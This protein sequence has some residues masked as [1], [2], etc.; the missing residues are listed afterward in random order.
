MARFFGKQRA[1]NKGTLRRWSCWACSLHWI[2]A[3]TIIIAICAVLSADLFNQRSTHDL[4]MAIHR[5]AGFCVLCLFLVRIAER[6]RSTP[7]E[8]A[9]NSWTDWTDW[10]A[11]GTHTVLYVLMFLIP[12][13]GWALTNARGQD[14]VVFGLKMP[15]IIQIYNAD[16][17]Y[18]LQ[19]FHGSTAWI[20]IALVGLHISAALWHHFVRRDTVLTDMIWCL[21]RNTD[22]QP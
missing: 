13:L 3:L 4:M 14:L 7:E 1:D 10:A 12:V 8:I 20:L 16:L 19:D 5:S 6:R 11:Q 15:R 9:S 2:T 18:T 22:D 17:S 21:K